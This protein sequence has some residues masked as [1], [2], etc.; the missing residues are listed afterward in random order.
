[1]QANETNLHSARIARSRAVCGRTTR[2]ATASGKRKSG[3]ATKSRSHS[4]TT[5]HHKRI[6][7]LHTFPFFRDTPYVH[8]LRAENDFVFRH[9]LNGGQRLKSQ[10]LLAELVARSGKALLNG[11][12]HA[13]DF[14][15]GLLAK[16]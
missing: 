10:P 1:M 7:I 8:D 15:I 14:R 11:N 4:L 3:H 9:R 12:C 6:E 5:I 13:N 16:I 2:A